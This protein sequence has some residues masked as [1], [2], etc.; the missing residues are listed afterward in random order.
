MGGP[1]AWGESWVTVVE[2]QRDPD[3]ARVMRPHVI[4]PCQQLQ[5]HRAMRLHCTCGKGLDYL[6]LA[7]L[8]TGV[9]VISSPRLL[10]PKRRQGGPSDLASV[11][12]G[13]DPEAIW[14]LLPWEAS[15][16]QREA[17]H[18]TAW[19]APESHPVL[20]PGSGVVGDTAKRQTFDC[21]KCGASHT[22]VNI[23][24]LRLVLQAIA[25]GEPTVR[26]APIKGPK[27]TP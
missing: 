4:A 13:D 14:A 1:L 18:R 11:I 3:N 23:N 21:P 25:N 10:P 8:S 17:A 24:L 16:R 20:P 5:R 27:A 12:E 9:M 15:M 7:S 6:A 22:F 19:K 2:A 26:L